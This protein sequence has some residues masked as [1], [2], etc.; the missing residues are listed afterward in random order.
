MNATGSERVT[1]FTVDRTLPVPEQKKL[2]VDA[3]KRRHVSWG[4]DFDSRA[5][6]LDMEIAES[7]DEAVKSQHR[8]NKEK[9]RL[10]LAA[11]FG[12]LGI[13]AKIENFVALGAK[14]MSILAHHNQLYDQVRRSFV[15]GAYYPALVGA[16]ALGER[17][18]NHL[19]LDLRDHFKETPEYRK[20]YRK[21]S[22][23]DWRLAIDTLSVWGILPQDT[24]DEFLELMDLRHRS[25]H[26]NASTP[27][28]LREDA[29][30]AALHMRSIIERQFGSHLPRPWFIEGTRGHVFIRKS[31]ENHPF[32]ETYFLP[33][34]P[35]VG[36]LFGMDYQDGSFSFFDHQD[37]GDG[38]WS[39]EEFMNQFNNR[40]HEKLAGPARESE[41]RGGAAE[42]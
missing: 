37:Y 39:D 5:T 33:R 29:L 36:P 21:Q 11:E 24:T 23:Q 34:C 1:I 20:V 2:I 14:P 12:E 30:A 38:S 41:T 13:D 3:G 9:V 18:L 32:I 28:A 8:E 6:I 4:M 25:I 40:D 35:F 10:G 16:C 22:F 17:I 42:R 26:F 19:V 7:W 27:T 15:V 31:W